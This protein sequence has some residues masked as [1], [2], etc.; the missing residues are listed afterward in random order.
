MQLREPEAVGLL[1]DHDRRVRDVDADLDHRR[2]DEH[3]ELPRLELRHQLAPLGRPQPPVH[4]PDAVALQ[5]AVAQPLR[6]ALGR[7]RD[8]RLR[9]LDQRADD[10]RLAAVVE[11]LAQAPVR[12]ARAILVTHAVLTGLR[13]AG[14]FAISLTWRS[15]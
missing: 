15:P 6:L 7:A 4:E 14:G 1:H 5:L 3:V 8:R 11:V 9:L 2:R 10:V 12:L 13:F